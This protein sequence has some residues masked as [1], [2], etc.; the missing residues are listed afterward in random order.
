M[1]KVT[2]KQDKNVLGGPLLACSYAPLTGF[3]RDGCCS[4]GPNDLGRHVVCAKVSEEFL[5]F[6]LRMGN[7]L[8]SPQPQYRFAGLKPGDRWCVC[9]TRWMEA[10]E[11]GVAPMVY[12]EGTN[13]SALQIIPLELLLEHSLV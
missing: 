8:I 3:M 5:E 9:A 4:T 13:E 11:A 6:Q 7:D 1:S 12:L 10:F 2:V